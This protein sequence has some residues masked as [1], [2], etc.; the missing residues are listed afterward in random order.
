MIWIAAGSFNDTRF[1]QMNE[2]RQDRL[3]IARRWLR[4]ALTAVVVSGVL[5]GRDVVRAGELDADPAVS[6]DVGQPSSVS[7][8][9]AHVRE[10]RRRV[11]ELATQRRLNQ[12]QDP[13]ASL[14]DDERL[15][16]ERIVNDFTLV[17]GDIVMTDKGAFVFKG[18]VHEERTPGDFEPLGAYPVR[19]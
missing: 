13:V 1:G 3:L 14:P 8:W 16:S 9:Q 7:A 18:Q 15:A 17:P 11:Q 4:F 2:S 6:T 12:L 5:T 10:E 19:R